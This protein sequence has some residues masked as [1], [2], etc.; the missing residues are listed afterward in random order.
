MSQ[1]MRRMIF[2]FEYGS[3]YT[4]LTVAR[5]DALAAQADVVVDWR[6]FL[7]G[8]L[9]K[10]RG[11]AQGPFLGNPPK[12]DYMW[13][14]LSRRAQA[15]GLHYRKPSVYPPNTLLTARIGALAAMQG[16]CDAFTREV[17]NLH[18]TEDIAIGTD[19]NLRRAL[20]TLG[21][22]PDE[23]MVAAQSDANKQLLRAAT[24]AAE[25]MGLF[26]SPSFTIGDELFWG[27]DRLEDALAFAQSS[28]RPMA[29]Q[30]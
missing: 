15:Y 29:A 26:G 2:W 5:I 22:N 1:S 28:G 11:M 12:L 4:Y 18:W 30:A 17:F 10:D 7:L 21:R 6:P 24:D 25:A 13:R 3:T 16:W 20:T 9:L 8:P 14:D 19:D 23:V 27:D